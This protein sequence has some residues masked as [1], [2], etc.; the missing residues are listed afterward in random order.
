[1]SQVTLFDEIAQDERKLE[2]AGWRVGKR[3]VE[4]RNTLGYTDANV[5]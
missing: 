3:A 4:S 5:I 1:M 2:K